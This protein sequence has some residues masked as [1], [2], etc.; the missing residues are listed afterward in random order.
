MDTEEFPTSPA[1]RQRTASP[2]ESRPN[3][4]QPDLIPIDQP[5][6]LLNEAPDSNHEP[7]AATAPLQIEN[8]D[9][10]PERVPSNSL[11][12][13]LML[14]VEAESTSNP[15]ITLEV[16]TP[17]RNEENRDMVL[18]NTE[19]EPMMDLDDPIVTNEVASNAVG[20][21]TAVEPIALSDTNAPAQNS[22]Q[23][24]L[25]EVAADT[26]AT[27]PT[28]ANTADVPAN[29]GQDT[30]DAIPADSTVMPEDG[31]QGAE[32][33]ADSSPYESST[34]SDSSPSDD[35]SSEED[36]DE[37]G[38]GDYAMLGPEEA[39]RILMQD[40]GGSD[41][42]GDGTKKKKAGYYALQMNVWKR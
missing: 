2:D 39:A 42:E 21:S 26:N 28:V 36:S 27:I 3:L 24:S 38:D 41:D 31:E 33:E 20:I 10:K 37:D 4:Q 19:E 34:D 16:S 14:Q 9:P 40:D 1:K 23:V 25:P 18:K 12:D 5:N 29:V 22:N 35:S 30:M 13:A 6:K 32:W 11:L 15:T 17:V 8:E 7:G